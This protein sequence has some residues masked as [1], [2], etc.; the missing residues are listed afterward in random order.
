MFATLED[1]RAVMQKLSVD[2][3]MDLTVFTMQEYLLGN[4]NERQ[5]AFVSQ[6][7]EEETLR[8]VAELFV[9]EMEKESATI[10]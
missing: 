9:A 6:L 3:L 7:I 4:I 10:N 2:E 5:A 8:R 1:A